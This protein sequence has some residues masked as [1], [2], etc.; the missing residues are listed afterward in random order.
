MVVTA[1]KTPRLT[2]LH[3]RTTAEKKL[4]L[5]GKVSKIFIFCLLTVQGMNPKSSRRA[6][7]ASRKRATSI[8]DNIAHFFLSE[9]QLLQ[10]AQKRAKESF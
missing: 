2:H 3:R 6:R 9:I 4:R 10:I 1:N 8:D 7:R 5:K